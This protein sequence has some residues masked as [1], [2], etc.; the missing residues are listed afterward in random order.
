MPTFRAVLCSY[1]HAGT[2]RIQAKAKDINAFRK[3]I[4]RHGNLKPDKFYEIIRFDPKMEKWRGGIG[5]IHYRSDM[6]EYIYSSLDTKNYC[7][8]VSKTTGALRRD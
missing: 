7:S 6:D 3:Y 8:I 5:T 4:I 2:H 1:E